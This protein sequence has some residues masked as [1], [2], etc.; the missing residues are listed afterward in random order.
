MEPKTKYEKVICW[1]GHHVNKA[2]CLASEA[3]LKAC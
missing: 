3:K 2:P 1:L